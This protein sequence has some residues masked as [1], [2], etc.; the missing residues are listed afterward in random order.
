MCGCGCA[1][2]GRANIGWKS[3][4]FSYSFFS[5]VWRCWNCVGQTRQSTLKRRIKPSTRLVID[6]LI[7]LNQPDNQP[8]KQDKD[9][10]GL[11][12]PMNMI[13]GGILCQIIRHFTR[14]RPISDR[15]ARRVMPRSWCPSFTK[16]VFS[17]LTFTT[18]YILARRV[19]STNCYHLVYQRR[20]ASC[21]SWG[22]YYPWIVDKPGFHRM[23]S[24]FGMS[25][26]RPGTWI[27]TDPQRLGRFTVA[28]Q[29]QWVP[30]KRE[31]VKRTGGNGLT[32][33]LGWW[34]NEE[35]ITGCCKGFFHDTKC[36]NT[37]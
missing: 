18:L 14:I 34:M 31:D 12:P 23:G 2:R 21:L 25:T 35:S 3:K 32:S 1:G 19:R 4:C 28:Q 17:L 5:F 22:S 36:D 11:R 16:D 37:W 27:C 26:W 33:R 13:I 7:Q 20:H 9:H 29:F 10:L 24:I 15:R 6:P 30:L 8:T